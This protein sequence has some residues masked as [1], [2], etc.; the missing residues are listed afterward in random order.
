MT[1][2][3]NEWVD[4]VLY[5][6][7]SEQAIMDQHADCIAVRAFLR[8]AG[9]PFRVEQRPNT[10]FMSP[11]GQVPLMQMQKELIAEYMPIVEFVGKK[12]VKMTNTLT[13]VEKADLYAHIAMIEEILRNAEIFLC[14]HVDNVYKGVTRTRY[15]SVYFWPLNVLL[16]M[17]KRRQIN[18]YLKAIGWLNYSLNDVFNECD[19]CFR[20]LSLKLSDHR[21]FIGDQPTELDALA[22]GHLYTILTM[23]MPINEMMQR[24]AQYENLINFCQ[25]IDRECFT[26][27]A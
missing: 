9:L 23:E 15:G 10:E 13:E 7:F 5:T 12:G 11:T 25:N 18:A 26:I 6:P 14:W 2:E 24:L 16:P 19:K 20:A 8:M 21:Y 3:G 27:N 17:L 1:D 4:V 22:F